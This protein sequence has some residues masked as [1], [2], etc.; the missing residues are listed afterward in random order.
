MSCRKICFCDLSLVWLTRPCVDIAVVVVFACVH[1]FLSCGDGKVSV[2][3]VGKHSKY[4][5]ARSD[6]PVR[7]LFWDIFEL[8]VVIAVSR[9][10][11]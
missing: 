10:I 11:C 3:D 9:I 5:G 1:V 7:E 2:K 6:I 8:F 4:A